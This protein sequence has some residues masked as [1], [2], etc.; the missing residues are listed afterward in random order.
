MINVEFVFRGRVHRAIVDG[1]EA[2]SLDGK[3]KVIY[4]STV[5]SAM[6]AGSV[7]GMGVEDN[8]RLERTAGPFSRF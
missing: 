8:R 7:D 2:R 5:I 4:S 1:Y 6:K 3:Y